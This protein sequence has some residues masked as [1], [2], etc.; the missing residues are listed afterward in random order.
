[1]TIREI[2]KFIESEYTVISRTPC[3][4]CGGEFFADDLEVALIDDSPYDICSCVCSKCGHERIFEFNAPFIED[5]SIK[6]VNKN[7]N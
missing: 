6:K 1:M 2:M 5:R 3:E 4:I 7:L